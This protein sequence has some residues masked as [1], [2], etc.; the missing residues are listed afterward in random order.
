MFS[1]WNPGVRE[2][3]V[4][5]LEGQEPFFG[6]SAE[7]KENPSVPPGFCLGLRKRLEGGLLAGIRQHGLDRVLYLDFDGH[8]DFGN[9]K[10]YV[11]VFDMAG[12]ERN[13]GL[14][15]DELLVASIIPSDEGR[16]EHRSP[17]TPPPGKEI[18]VREFACAS[19]LAQLLLRRPG[20]SERVLGDV[21]EG[22]GKELVKGILATIGHGGAS[23]FSP[24]S[25]A[26]A[27]RL[28]GRMG[29][30]LRQLESEGIALDGAGPRPAISPN[31]RA[32]GL[33]QTYCEPKLTPEA[34]LISP[35]VCISP[36]GYVFHVFPLPHLEVE[37]E[38]DSALEAARAY[39]ERA[40]RSSEFSSLF[41][42]AD[43]LHRKVLK[44]VQSRH[45]AQTGDLARSEDYEKYKIWARLIDESGKRN[46]PGA[47]EITATDYYADPPAEVVVPLDPKRSAKDNARTYYR[48]YSK[49]LRAEKTLQESLR[50]LAED[51]KELAQLR[52]A[53][54]RS[55]DV[56]DLL[57]VIPRLE[58]MAEREGIVVKSRTKRVSR[59]KAL[60]PGAS[61]L[62]RFDKVRGVRAGIRA[63]AGKRMGQE[64]VDGSAEARSII[65]VRTA[66][67]PDGSTF[68]IGGS[69]KQNDELITKA[70]LPGDM[71]FHAKGVKGAHVLARPAPG[72]ELT[73]EAMLGAAKVAAQKSG[74]KDSPKVDVDYIDA[75]K[76][77]KPRGSAP[78]FVTYTGQKT[79]MVTLES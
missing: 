26:V 37:D 44:K 18:D 4:L 67:G 79:V 25:A 20:S 53:L 22:A 24:E 10:R 19:P 71:W 51:Q 12:R 62:R 40:S 6:F 39:R 64:K 3:L 42:A 34:R 48:T 43:S 46:P 56:A 57:A 54:E 36:K 60:M 65:R 33:P 58:A 8:D 47:T 14:Y 49:L 55:V 74:A 1:V 50:V 45:E 35:A 11:L 2:R 9:V 29:M 77:R 41:A 61:K 68:L 38:F 7:K 5:S 27:A 69:A 59:R 28:L 23:P 21:I 30:E 78:G 16:F 31:I 66:E 13:I 73:E 52:D 72:R 70:R 76:V 75:M 15:E 17:Y 63:G 32:S